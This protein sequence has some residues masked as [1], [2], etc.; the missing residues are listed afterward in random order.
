MPV[1]RVVIFLLGGVSEIEKEPTRPARSTWSRSPAR[2]SRWCSPPA[3]PPR[4]RSPTPARSPARSCFL[5]VWS[6][7]AVAVFNLL[8]GLPLDGGRL[9]RAGVWRVSGDRLTGTRAAAWGGRAVAALV[10]VGAVATVRPDGALGHRQRA[11]GQPA[12]RVHL[13]RRHPVAQRGDGDRADAGDRDRQPGPPDADGAAGPAG[14]RGAAPGLDRRRAGAGGGRRR[15]RAARPG[16]RGARDGGA[17]GAPAVD[18]GRG[19]GPPAGAGPG[20]GRLAVRRRGG[21]GVPPDAGVGV[22]GRRSGRRHRR[23]ARRRRRRPDP[24]GP[25]RRPPG[26]LA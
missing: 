26:P 12:G 8:P 16:L 24:A 10:L 7:L 25:R 5:V 14:G 2:W 1:R 15:R 13:G 4:C 22:P 23:R 9:V 20:A 17:G 3:R 19:R 11:A 18:D 6:N 21:R